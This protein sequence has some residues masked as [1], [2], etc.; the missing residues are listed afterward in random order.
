MDGSE[1]RTYWL[2]PNSTTTKT[3]RVNNDF[4]P[5]SGDYMIFTFVI[6]N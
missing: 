3:I 5:D 4:E 2:P 1:F 6:K